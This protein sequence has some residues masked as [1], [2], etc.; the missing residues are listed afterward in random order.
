[1]AAI[2]NLSREKFITGRSL[3]LIIG[4]LATFVKQVENLPSQ[5]GSLHPWSG[6]AMAVL[7]AGGKS[8]QNQG[9]DSQQW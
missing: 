8:E 5:L 4:N 2:Q 1:M 9:I 6:G 3:K 7:H